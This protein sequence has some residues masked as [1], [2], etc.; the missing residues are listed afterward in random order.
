MYSKLRE[1][2]ILFVLAVT[3]VARMVLQHGVGNMTV[4]VNMTKNQKILLS[5]LFRIPS[6]DTVHFMLPWLG[7]V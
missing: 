4:H 2:G 1:L 7:V 3:S 6:P 5:E